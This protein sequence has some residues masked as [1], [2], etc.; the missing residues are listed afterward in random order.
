MT[1]Y[2]FVRRVLAEHGGSCHAGEL[3]TEILADPEASR[4]LS[5]S[6][7]YKRLLDNIKQSGFIEFDGAIVRRTARRV[8]RRRP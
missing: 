2:E 4:R 6:Q 3:L 1:L 7:G 5:A 8:G